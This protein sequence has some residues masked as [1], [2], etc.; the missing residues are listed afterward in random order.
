M[1]RCLL[2]ILSIFFVFQLSGQSDFNL[3]QIEKDFRKNYRFDEQAEIDYLF[4]RQMFG[5]DTITRHYYI[6]MFDRSFLNI[7]DNIYI[8]MDETEIIS[9]QDVD[10]TYI[11]YENGRLNAEGENLDWIQRLNEYNPFLIP[12]DFF[13]QISNGRVDSSYQ[14]NGKNIIVVEYQTAHDLAKNNYRLWLDITD[15]RL[16]KL[17]K[18]VYSDYL[19]LRKFIEVRYNN[20]QKEDFSQDFIDIKDELLSHGDRSLKSNQKQRIAVGDTM[21]GYSGL[22]LNGDTLRPEQMQSDYYLID[23]W[24]MACPPCMRAVPAMNDAHEKFTDVMFLGINTA[25]SDLG[26]LKTYKERKNIS[27]VILYSN[28]IEKDYHLAYPTFVIL[29]SKMVVQKVMEGFTENDFDSFI[30]FFDKLK[31]ENINQ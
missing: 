11:L 28:Q 20:Q 24:Y 1:S 23:F 18:T 7:L 14:K 2:V 29:D 25:D 26:N 22:Q 30:E 5:R 16:L 15:T 12:L 19:H 10:S 17:Q 6:K 31:E 8:K 4:T 13:N 27:Y 21:T 3:R 9:D